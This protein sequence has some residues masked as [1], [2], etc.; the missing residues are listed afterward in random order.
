MMAEVTLPQFYTDNM[1]L[2]QHSKVV[3]PGTAT[4]GSNVTLSADWL[5]KPV[6]TK[7]GNDGKFS[8][9]LPTPQAGG[10]YTLVISDGKGFKTLQNVLIGEVWL[11][12]GQSN[13]E[14][15]VK[16]DWA[17]LMNAD[18]VAATMHRPTLRMLKLK[19]V[20][21][22]ATLDDATVERG[23]V[24]SSPAEATF[25]AIG[26]LYGK[27]L[28]DSLNIPVGV[29]DATWGGTPIEAWTPLEKLKDVP[30][31]GIYREP[32]NFPPDCFDYPGGLFNAMI[33]PLTVMPVAGVLWYQGC[34]N[35]DRA[36]GYEKCF[37]NMIEGWRNAF[38]NVEMPFYYVQLAG[39]ILPVNV[40]PE[41]N[42][43]RL[44]DAQ[45]KVRDLPYVGMAT[46]IDLGHPTDIHPTNKEE[47]ARRLILLA[48][49]K[50][51][52]KPQVCEAPE[53]KDIRFEGNKI[54]L[55]FDA[56]V[57]STGGV[58]LGFIIGDKEGKWAYAHS[59]QIND[60]II[61]LTS[62]LID[63]PSAVRYNWADY[64]DGNLYGENNLPVLPFASD[65][66]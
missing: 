41:S 60:R 8:L 49:D 54:V 55:K 22:V 16:G 5:A 21:S 35:V 2:Q 10:P 43:A 36:C 27:M 13:M 61:E 47:V 12:S 3:I 50:T 62:I 46:A 65:I 15:P 6:N 51:Y 42:W 1:V 29:I 19:R 48:L 17:K 28:Q 14:F 20:T 44:R 38:G 30:C 53:Y 18:E 40:Q 56:P 25:S 7:A 52:G 32:Q 24:D 66:K 4:P 37:R 63:K 33:N 59:K 11:C 23:W 31:L 26:Y 34:A 39:H 64:P 57:K 45:Q 58:A 9:E